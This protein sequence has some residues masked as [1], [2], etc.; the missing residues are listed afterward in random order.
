MFVSSFAIIIM[1]YH[2]CAIN[3][4]ETSVRIKSNLP[5]V[6]DAISID[7]ASFFLLRLSFS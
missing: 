2:G 6:C 4:D 5:V 1:F 3:S 7:V